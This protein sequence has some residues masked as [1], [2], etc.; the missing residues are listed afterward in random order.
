MPHTPEHIDLRQVN[1]PVQLQGFGVSDQTRFFKG[2]SP[3]NLM[4]QDKGILAKLPAELIN[5]FSRIA[6]EGIFG[7]QGIADVNRQ[8]GQQIRLGG[9]QAVRGLQQN[10]GRRLGARSGAI[11]NVVANRVLAPQLSQ[12]AG[13][14][15]Q[16]TTQ[17]LAS[18][19][20]GLN[21]ITRVM[22]SLQNRFGARWWENAKKRKV[23]FLEVAKAIGGIGLD[24]AGLFAAPATGGASVAATQ[25]VKRV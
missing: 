25:A 21:A 7:Q 9:R 20:E 23:G 6:D 18:R 24:V 3:G 4:D 15:A 16:L 17:N 14:S 10:I 8:F 1:Q 19:V 12:Q 13:V 11:T 5:R 22:E 2:F